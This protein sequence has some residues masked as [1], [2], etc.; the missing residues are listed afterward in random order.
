MDS[1]EQ[2]LA[3]KRKGALNE[4]MKL[5][6]PLS[7][8]SENGVPNGTYRKLVVILHDQVNEPAQALQEA[9]RKTD[10]YQLAER[11]Y[12]MGKQVNALPIVASVVKQGSFAH[13]LPTVIAMIR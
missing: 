5:P 8:S 9:D 13:A 1:K 11:L 6:R 4:W 7:W 2:A 12:N 3:E 10:Y